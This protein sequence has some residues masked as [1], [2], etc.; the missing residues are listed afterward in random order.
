MARALRWVV[1]IALCV[2]LVP[3]ARSGAAATETRAELQEGARIERLATGLRA[4]RLLAFAPDGALVIGSKGGVVWRLEPPFDQPEVLLRLGGYPHSVAFRAGNILIARTDGIYRARYRP[5]EAPLSAER[6]VALPGGGGHNS[7]TV[8]VG[9]DGRVYAAL[10]LSGNCSDQYIGEA[11]DFRHR[12]GGI[13][14]LDESRRPLRWRPFATGL[15]NPVGF[16]WHPGT[17]VLYATNNGP[18]HHGYDEPAE[19]FVRAERGSFFGFPWYVLIDGTIVRDDCASGDPAEPIGAVERPVATFPARNAPLGM[20]F[21]PAAAGAWGGDAFVALHGSWATK[22]Y[23]GTLGPDSTRRPP[24][25]VRVEFNDGRATGKVYPVVTGFQDPGSGARWAR[26]A[27]I[28]FD[29]AGDLYF[30]SDDGAD[31]L[32]RVRRPGSGG[33]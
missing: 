16:D 15:R 28:A 14:L 32:F 17:G 6:W 9:P 7:R 10:G 22:P 4:P 25:V 30:T 29:A 13:M 21:A 20:A 18:D 3:W 33:D 24:A 31:A 23:G 27:A 11:Y 12:R 8:G 5:R 1:A 19:Y 26:P 2:V